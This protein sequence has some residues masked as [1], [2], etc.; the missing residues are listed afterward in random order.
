MVDG[1]VYDPL[2]EHIDADDGYHD[3]LH[4]IYTVRD[5]CWYAQV[6]NVHNTTQERGA[7]RTGGLF[8]LANL[9]VLPCRQMCGAHMAAEA[10]WNRNGLQVQ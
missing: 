9:L 3:N 7:E 8:L 6:W 5:I 10:Y 4:P 1:L 2:N